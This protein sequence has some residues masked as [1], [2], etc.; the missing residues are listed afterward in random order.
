MPDSYT[1]RLERA[2]IDIHG[3]TEDLWERADRGSL[4]TGDAISMVYEMRE[5]AAV[6]LG[7]NQQDDD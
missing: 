3:Y 2:L 4:A 7:L 5:I 1:L 6:A